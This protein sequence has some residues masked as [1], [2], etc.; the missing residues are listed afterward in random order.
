LE[1]KWA[2]PLRALRR[3]LKTKESHTKWGLRFCFAG[4]FLNLLQGKSAAD[5]KGAGKSTGHEEG[6]S[7]KVFDYPD[8]G[9]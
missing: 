8:K 6:K 4:G 9:I 1:K 2:T 7:S 3:P 5:K